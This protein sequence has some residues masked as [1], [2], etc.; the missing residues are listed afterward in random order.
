M[1]V[2]TRLIGLFFLSVA[3]F[4]LIGWMAALSPGFSR[5][6]QWGMILTM[7]LLIVGS[8]AD[9]GIYPRLGMSQLTYYGLLIA[10]A[11]AMSVGGM[12]GWLSAAV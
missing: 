8:L 2:A 12:A 3:I 11:V 1:A 9:D 6:A 10:I 4:A 5:F 7:I